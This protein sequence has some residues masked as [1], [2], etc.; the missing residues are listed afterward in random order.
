[1]MSSRTGTFKGTIEK[2]DGGIKVNGE[3]VSVFQETDPS[4]IPWGR[5]GADFKAREDCEVLSIGPAINEDMLRRPD[6]TC[7]LLYPLD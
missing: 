2:T 3:K 7:I 6:G 5:V 4:K 1:M